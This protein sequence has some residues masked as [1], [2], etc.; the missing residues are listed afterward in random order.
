[1]TEEEIARGLVDNIQEHPLYDNLIDSDAL[2]VS[3]AAA[4]RAYGDARVQAER[5][6]AARIASQVFVNDPYALHPDI[7]FDMLNES[8]QTA[9]HSIAQTIAGLI[10]D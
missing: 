6:R 5:T 8:A 1:M 9:A 7:P 10:L 3:I 2:V 4:L